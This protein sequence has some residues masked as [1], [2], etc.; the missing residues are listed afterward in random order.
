MQTAKHALEIPGHG[1]MISRLWPGRQREHS[2]C[3]AAWLYRIVTGPAH[4]RR[5]RT[6]G[7]SPPRFAPLHDSTGRAPW[8]WQNLSIRCPSG[9]TPIGFRR[10]RRRHL[11][12]HE[13][14]SALKLPVAAGGRADE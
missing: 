2:P 1:I 11:G 8:I 6:A 3:A 5:R 10:P 14:V 13:G 7:Q 4:R 12:A 9:F